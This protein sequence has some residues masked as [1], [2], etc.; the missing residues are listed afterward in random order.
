LLKN[1]CTR[2]PLDTKATISPTGPQPARHY[3]KSNYRTALQIWST[4]TK[5]L[6]SPLKIKT[7]YPEDGSSCS[8][9]IMAMEKQK[10]YLFEL[11]MRNFLLAIRPQIDATR[12]QK[13]RFE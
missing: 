7:L 10:M 12:S 9:R 13:S 3:Q 2:L 1:Y 5:T 8:S 4:T 6:T 11:E